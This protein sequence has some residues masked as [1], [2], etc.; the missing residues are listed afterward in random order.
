VGEAARH[1]KVLYADQ[2]VH[3][4]L[5]HISIRISLAR[6][7]IK[8]TEDV[9]DRW[10]QGHVLIPMDTTFVGKQTAR[11]LMARRLYLSGRHG[12][13]PAERPFSGMGGK[14]ENAGGASGLPGRVENHYGKARLVARWL[15]C[16]GQYRGEGT[17]RIDA[18]LQPKLTQEYARDGRRALGSPRK[19][20]QTR[21]ASEPTITR[22]TG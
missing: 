9:K 19:K 3:G 7:V 5:M 14:S 12:D 1:T 18:G 10:G 17:F 6:C 4:L 2:L 15:S 16:P 20:S 22:E 11:P 8:V 21:A 13:S